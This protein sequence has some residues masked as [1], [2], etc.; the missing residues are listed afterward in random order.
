MT[1]QPPQS[2]QRLLFLDNLRYVIVFFVMWFH[3]SAGYSGW[4]EYYHETQAG[5][6]FAILHGII[7][8]IRRMPLLF[9]VAGYFAMPSLVGRGAAGFFMR[10]AKRLGV[11]WL[12]CI[13]LVGPLMPF[14][15][16]YSQSFNGLASGAYADFWPAFI[17]SGFSDWIT[18]I[19]FVVNPQFHQMHFWFTSV[20]L[21]LFALMAIGRAVWQKWGPAPHAGPA[22][23]WSMLKVLVCTALVIAVCKT[24]FILLETPSGVLGFFLHFSPTQFST[25]GGFFALGLYARHR[26][27]FSD[28]QVPGWKHFGA[29]FGGL[30]LAGGATASMYFLAGEIVPQPLMVFTG[31]LGEAFLGLMVMVAGVGLTR[32]Y[33]NK[34]STINANLA[35]NSY[36]VYLIHYPILLVLR[37]QMLTWDAPTAV[38]Y[39]IAFAGTAV[40][41]YA[42][43]QY[44]CRR[45]NLLTVVAL[46]GMHVLLLVYGFPRSSYSHT[47]LDR[48]AQLRSVVPGPALRVTD[49]LPE[50]QALLAFNDPTIA[51]LAH[52]GDVLYYTYGDSSLHMRTDDGETRQLTLETT[53]GA[54]AALPAGGLAAIEPASGRIIELDPAGRVT[55]TLVDSSA[56]LGKPQDLVADAAG[57]LYFTA[58]RSG[59]GENQRGAVHYRD[60][61]GQVRAVFTDSTLQ[62][63]GLAL[64][65]GVLFANA[66]ADT[67]VW[68]MEVATDGSLS[69]R[70]AFAELFRADGRYRAA[71]LAKTVDSQAEEMAVDARGR[72]Y[73]GTRFGVQ[74]FDATGALL[75]IVNFPELPI[76]FTPKPPRSCV[77]GGD[78]LYVA[79]DDEI[80]AVPLDFE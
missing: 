46:V 15:G 4:P 34:P 18:P 70:R 76:S 32:R 60:A 79:C 52:A 1:A 14:L 27:W 26:N 50:N 37:L 2:P 12:L 6:F 59:T 22:T 35:A 58:W 5:G 8:S 29:L 43:S 53:V 16:Y 71:G 41:S 56:E 7:T 11:P 67:A 39:L 28:G 13:F 38:K 61:T 74:V 9:F 57:G 78:R 66:A 72:L 55:A 40:I 63:R 77:L 64:G 54:L 80:F 21:Q 49:A 62:V 75:G 19:A 48:Q 42:I 20:L 17:K 73:V 45:S 51:R 3:V 30:V 10:K 47:L 33:M 44:L 31:L 24:L 36:Y 68:A 65:D 23:P 25:Y 69:G